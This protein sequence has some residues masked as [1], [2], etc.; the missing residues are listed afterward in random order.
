M[1]TFAWFIRQIKSLYEVL[2]PKQTF[3]KNK[4]VTGKNKFSVIESFYFTYFI[5]FNTLFT[6]D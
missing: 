1:W 3:Q 4:V 6:V 2:K 5:S